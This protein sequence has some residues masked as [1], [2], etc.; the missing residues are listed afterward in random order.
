MR[1]WFLIAGVALGVLARLPS[2]AAESVSVLVL[3]DRSC[4]WER[5]A[6]LDRKLKGEVADLGVAVQ[7]G[8]SYYH[9]LTPGLLSGYNLSVMLYPPPQ[10]ATAEREMYV[11]KARLLLDYVRSGG[12]LLVLGDEQY[13]SGQSLNEVLAP[14]DAEVL[15]ESVLDEQTQFRQGRFFREYFFTTT[16]ILPH[17]L[18][19]G[20]QELCFPSAWHPWKAGATNTMRVGP[21]WQI[22]VRGNETA[23]SVG[24][25]ADVEGQSTYSTAPPIMAVRSFGEGRVALLP[26]RS[27]TTLQSGH[28]FVFESLCYARGDLTRLIANTLLWLSEPARR[29]SRPSGY[30]EPPVG[31]ERQPAYSPEQ[32]AQMD[33][34]S[35]M[36]ALGYRQSVAA[37]DHHYRPRQDF[38]GVIGV[39]SDFSRRVSGPA[40]AGGYGSVADYCAKARE[41]GYDFVAFTER[42]EALDEARWRELVAQCDAASSQQFLAIP[43]IEIEDVY[44]DRYACLDLPGWVQEQWLDASGR[45]L[46]DHP[47]FYFGLSH[48]HNVFLAKFLLNPRE[49]FLRPWFAKFYAGM[50]VFGYNRGDQLLAEALDWYRVCQSNDYNLIPIVSHRI[51]CPQDLAAVTGYRV[52]VL[53][54]KLS[55]VPKAFRYGWY[56]P[57]DVYLSSGPRLV[58]WA[59]ENGRAAFRDEPWQLFIKLVSDVPLREVTV[60]DRDQVFRRYFP[61]TKR[62]AADILGYH[63]KQRFFLLTVEDEQ[64]GRLISPALYTSDVRHSTY[65]CT[66]LQNTINGMIDVNRAGQSDHFRV[67]GLYVTGWDSL[68]VPALVSGK[69]VLPESGIEYGLAP[70]AGAVGPVIH[71][72]EGTEYPVAQRLMAFDCGDV[73]I[74]DNRYNWKLLPGSYQTRTELADSLVR[75]TSFTPRAYGQNIML[76]E[77]TVRLKRDLRL[78]DRKGPE[79]VLLR[80]N[81]GPSGAQ[82]RDFANAASEGYPQMCLVSRDGGKRVWTERAESVEAPLAPGGYVAFYPDFWGSLAVFPLSEGLVLKTGDNAEIGLERPDETLTAGT[83]LTARSLV[84]RGAFGENTEAEFDR[85]RDAYGLDGSPGYHVEVTRG[86]LL[87]SSYILR[88]RAADACAAF[89]VSQMDM[90]NPLPVIVEGLNERCDAVALDASTGELRRVATFENAG[91]LTVDASRGPVSL[92]VGN[93]VACDRSALWLSLLREEAGWSLEVHNPTAEAIVSRVKVPPWLSDTIGTFAGRLTI[94]A[95][96]TARAPCRPREPHPEQ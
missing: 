32:L 74:L 92:A 26:T 60:W 86:E 23:R 53:A 89:S 41:L 43:G 78:T 46:A 36:I 19:E 65:M 10:G 4:N 39:H 13:G 14:L 85:L 8:N 31:P 27:V 88:V 96:E 59:I 48:G 29:A 57:R 64:G 63:D 37:I 71:A 73:N 72:A 33:V 54:G 67:Q 87:S 49:G 50:E 3:S 35:R 17:P 38:V 68:D 90:P 69:D 11:Q 6:R 30:V 76:V 58:E 56:T 25:R 28:H 20:V 47:G 1:A 79:V 12:G 66:D 93:A 7:E 82:A 18:A 61:R 81:V 16:G 15:P 55:D 44:G 2:E 94:P 42:F 95:G 5:P 40:V 84:V 24:W 80:L 45:Y 9:S 51:A 70:T 21:D 83:T 77:H 22:V 62:F 52:H 75:L 34:Y 91:W